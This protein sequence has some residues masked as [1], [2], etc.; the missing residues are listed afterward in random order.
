MRR[1]DADDISVVL[2]HYLDSVLPAAGNGAPSPARIRKVLSDRRTAAALRRRLPGTIV[3]EFNAILSDEAYLR[4]LA[5]VVEERHRA[6]AEAPAL[7]LAAHPLSPDEARRLLPGEVNIAMLF[8][9][10]MVL[11]QDAL[12]ALANDAAVESARVSGSGVN[13]L[14]VR[15]DWR[16]ADRAHAARAIIVDRCGLP[17]QV[18]FRRPVPLHA[19]YVLHLKR[20]SER[21]T[22]QRASAECRQAGLGEVNPH[23]CAALADDKWATYRLWTVRAP[24]ESQALHVPR[25]W[26]LKRTARA[27]DARRTMQEALAKVCAIYVQ[28]RHGTEGRL[29]ARFERAQ[30][31]AAARHAVDLILPDDDAVIREARGNVCCLG[32]SGANGGEPR[33]IALRVHVAWDGRRFV[34]ESGFAQVAGDE[35]PDVASRGRG[36]S[37]VAIAEALSNL[38][39]RDGAPCRWVPVTSRDLAEVRAACEAA[40]KALN[41]CAQPRDYLKHIGL[42]VVL[43]ATATGRLRPVLL[44]ANARPAGLNHS[45]WLPDADAP[46]ADLGVTRALFRGRAAWAGA[47]SRAGASS[48]AA[49]TASSRRQ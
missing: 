28:P 47:G 22:H 21:S 49:T 36:G 19:A 43:E 44:E 26:L 17:K 27:D 45:R 13:V 5:E 12:H 30:A 35:A 37:I 33:Q 3:A 4:R 34:A 7:R 25:T 15:L 46:G 31:E 29:V 14:A 48:S 41:P 11:V 9:A 23:P 18:A 42:D 6:G 16:T 2:Q 10:E 39:H 40:A 24:L 1:L 32:A 20:L 8:N 38:R